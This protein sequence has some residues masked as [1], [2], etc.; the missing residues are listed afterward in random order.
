MEAI[1]SWQPS[2]RYPDP[3]VQVL[4]PSFEKYRIALAAVERL[5]TGFRFTE[6][7]VWF[8][9]GRY[10]LFS[11]IPNNRIMKWEEETGAVGVFRRPSDFANGNTRDRQGRLVTCEHGK[12]RV[13]R[14]EYDG[15]ITVLAD[16]FEGKPLNAPND[17]V[18]K[19]DGS[20]W[21]TD[22]PFG[23]SNDYE[24]F[25]AEPQLPTNVYRID[26]E[27]G[28]V[29][30]ATGDIL[31]PNGLAFSPDESKL[32]VVQS[33]ARPQRNIVA[34]DVVDGKLLRN[35]RVLVDC[36]PGIPDGLRVDEDGNL[37]CGWGMGDPEL[38]GV[39]VF[40]PQGERIGR[41]RLPERC[42]NLCFG[43]LQRN[44]LFMAGSQSLYSLYVNTRGAV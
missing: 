43:G 36:G 12:R 33:R 22:P 18:A 40:S 15:R 26:G 35:P 44:R 19:S 38:D 10:L 11:D 9:D 20:L 25:R 7:P 5:A 8:G 39:M 28:T 24:G 30:V 16:R 42:A 21:F 29:T 23:I 2:P 1:P 6:G 34:C 17:V 32:Y 4:H 37:W 41:I 3:A 31:G 27:S 14:T 13:T